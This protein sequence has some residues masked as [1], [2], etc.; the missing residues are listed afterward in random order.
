MQTR[1]YRYRIYC[2]TKRVVAFEKF[3]EG[4]GLE[5]CPVCDQPQGKLGIGC[6]FEITPWDPKQPEGFLKRQ[7]VLEI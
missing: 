2:P 7:I 6:D 1:Q 5:M 3:S 4:A